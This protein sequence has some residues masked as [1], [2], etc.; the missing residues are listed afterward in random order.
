MRKTR[1]LENHAVYH[2]VARA[3]RGEF[4]LNSP[5]CKE[6]FIDVLKRAKEKYPFKLKH[7]C[8]MSNHIHLM[9][10]PVSNT[11]LS[12]LMQW[13]LSVFAVKINKLFGN[14]GHVW[15]DRFKSKIIDGYRQYVRTFN[16]ISN[17]P[18]KAEMCKKPL[19]YRF[20]GFKSLFEKIYD[21]IEPPD[22]IISHFIPGLSGLL[23]E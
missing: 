16:Y 1:I 23:L 19:D 5:G 22:R 14:K 9:I 17:N 18:V 21:L 10:E 11:K 12:K 2:V 13:V 7:Y 6:M 8:I 15:Y 3:N 4:I 20:S